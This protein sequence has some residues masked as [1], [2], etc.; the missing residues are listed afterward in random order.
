MEIEKTNEEL[1]FNILFFGMEINSFALR[2][3][4]IAMD[5]DVFAY[6]ERMYLQDIFDLWLKDSDKRLT[7]IKAVTDATGMGT[8]PDTYRPTISDLFL[9]AKS[10]FDACKMFMKDLGD[11]YNRRKQGFD[12]G[13][14]IRK[15]FEQSNYTKI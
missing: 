11:L 3:M 13:Y 10:H 1:H 14:E 2:G 7:D 9:K 15:M 6:T 5:L 8:H 12:S 4:T